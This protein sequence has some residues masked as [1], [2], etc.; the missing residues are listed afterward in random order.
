MAAIHRA[1]SSATTKPAG[2]NSTTVSTIWIQPSQAGRKP[3]RTAD[4]ASAFGASLGADGYVV[5]VWPFR[6]ERA[7]AKKSMS[8]CVTRSGS[9]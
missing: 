2:V 4:A 1:V 9:S 3:V 7:G 8:S 5:E 6:V